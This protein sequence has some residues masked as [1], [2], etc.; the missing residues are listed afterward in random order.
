MRFFRSR[1]GVIV[2]GVLLLTLLFLVR[3]GANRLRARIVGEIS[4]ALGRP[5]D[6]ASVRVRLLPQPGFDL[7]NFVVHDDPAFSAEPMLRAQQVTASLRLT[8]LMRGRLEIAR[9]DLTEPS[10]NLVRGVAGHWNIENLVERAEKIPV[11][12]TAKSKSERRPGFPY[13]DST[14]GR[15]NFKLGP[16]KKPYALTDADFSLW[17][18]SE[19]TWGMRLKAQ[20]VRTDFNLTDTGVLQVSGTWRRAAS[21]RETPMQFALE[22]KRAQLG[23]LTKLV[24]HSDKGWRGAVELSAT[25]TGAPANL[26]LTV[27]ASAEDFRR[28]DVLGGGKMLLAAQ[29]NARYSSVENAL[30]EI[31]CRAPVGEGVIIVN[32]RVADPLT[33]PAYDLVVSAQGLPI[34]SLVEFARHAKK[35]VPGDLIAT[36]QVDAEFRANRPAGG[37]AGSWEGTGRTSEL[38]LRSALTNAEIALDS[39]P[40]AISSTNTN[41]SGKSRAVGAGTTAGVQSG[42]QVYIGP[43]RAALGRPSPVTVQGRIGREGYDFE[44]HGETQVQRLF[45]AAQII[46]I[47]APQPIAEGSAK[48]DLQLIG[49][50]SGLAPLRATGKAQ[51]HSVR[52]QVPGLNAPLDIVSANLTLTPEQVNV[53]NL[54]VSA[55]DTSWRGSLIA[56]RPC[57]MTI[58]CAVRL[59]LHANEIALDRL[60]QLLNPRVRKEPWYRILSSS[61]SSGAPY[62]SALTASGKLAVDRVVIDKLVARRVTTNLEL[63]N[64]ALWLSELRADVLGGQ[65]KGE[66][67]ADFTAKPPQYSGSG[68]FQGVVLGQLAEA[69]KDDWIA[70]TA[71][72]SYRATTS[73]VTA[74]EL[75]SSATASLQINVSAGMLPHIM[76]TDGAAP[77]QM[78]HLTAHLALRDGKFDIQAGELETATDVFHLSGTASLTQT[79]NLKL[80]RESAPGFSITGTLTEPHVAQVATPETRAA[81]KP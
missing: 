19:N 31:G 75:F 60:N 54:A 39:V 52:A 79:L 80:T 42:P 21:L 62:F 66:W 25:L 46:G 48:V 77:L 64:R 51:L 9:L 23:Q 47:P 37:T 56:A 2:C 20:P 57:T 8:S 24:Y 73:G 70:G 50:W 14:S 35:W 71:T 29:C 33:V 81:L 58:T 32:G 53:Q 7:E 65:H 69:M 44:I 43:F 30:S 4:L 78:R 40:I 34:Q 74:Q 27:N 1:R 3:P 67:K 41:L 6:V 59:D 11:A 45:Q 22:W 61:V 72:A 15:I 36:G 55:A 10:L 38:Q 49:D 16:E 18:E 13:I 5:V 12:P 17:Q 26:S 68:T 63:K 76:L 28:Y